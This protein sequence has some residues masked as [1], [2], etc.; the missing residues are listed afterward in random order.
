M[1]KENWFL[2][3]KKKIPINQKGQTLYHSTYLRY[4]EKAN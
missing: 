1:E 4:L 3:G 2:C